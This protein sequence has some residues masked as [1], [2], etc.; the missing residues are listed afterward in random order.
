MRSWIT[1][2]RGLWAVLCG[3]ALGLGT[4]APAGADAT[5]DQQWALGFMKATQL[6]A[7]SQGEGVTVGLIDS[8][9]DANHPDLKGNV[10][11]G[12][13]RST[14]GQDG[15]TN[16]FTGHG[17]AMASLIAGHGHGTGN[18]DGI[19][20]IAPKAKIL[21]VRIGNKTG[22]GHPD[23]ISYGIQA[24]ADAGAKIICVAIVTNGTDTMHAAIGYA[25]L[26]GAVVVAGVGNVPEFPVISW[27]AAYPG[28]I[29]VGG[30]GR[31][32]K[33]AK[34]SATGNAVG[35]ITVLAPSDDVISA[36]PGG[37]YAAGTGTSNSTAL[38]TG[39]A[40]LIAAKY[41]EASPADILRRLRDSATDGGDPGYDDRY[42]YGVVNP[43]AALAKTVPA[44]KDATPPAVASGEPTQAPQ[45]AKPP[46]NKTVYW[47]QVAGA[48]FVICGLPVIAVVAIVL[49]IVRRRRRR[50]AAR[51]SP[52][53]P[54]GPSP[55]NTDAWRP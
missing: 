18:R 37:R 10:L 52:P 26:K 16:D 28:V 38:V 49:L 36:Q 2:R 48:V 5:R 44:R 43:V 22:N 20:G 11:K 33:V 25:N 9:V 46:G 1:A 35:K 41:P 34:V 23:D 27:P 17:T 31:D 6:A 14:D 39:V 12:I 30:V 51:S 40:A 7:I 47:L 8:G 45:A 24:A 50:Q 21:P 53:P 13:D 32:G 42:G 19:L 55:V 54:A 29:A 15:T 4:A 3:L